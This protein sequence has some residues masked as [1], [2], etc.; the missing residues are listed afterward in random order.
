MIYQKGGLRLDIK[1]NAKRNVCSVWLLLKN[2][3]YQNESKSI[4]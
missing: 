2:K 1:Q 4:N 3:Y